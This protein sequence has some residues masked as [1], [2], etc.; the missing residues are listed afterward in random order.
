MG[1]VKK[2]SYQ[3]IIS[4]GGTATGE[5]T[6]PGIQILARAYSMHYV[7][8]ST[9]EGDRE[10]TSHGQR[11]GRDQPFAQSGRSATRALLNDVRGGGGQK[12]CWL[13]KGSWMSPPSPAADFL[14]NPVIKWRPMGGGA[15]SPTPGKRLVVSQLVGLGWTSFPPPLGFSVAPSLENALSVTT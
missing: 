15:R 5:L 13:G 12:C 1:F 10:V 8:T 11:R 2:P 14:R 9:L 7:Y 6:D 4:D 3:L